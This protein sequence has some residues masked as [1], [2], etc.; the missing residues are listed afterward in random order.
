MTGHRTM[1]QSLT[2]ADLEEVRP[3]GWSFLY[4][5]C[6]LCGY[7]IL[8]PVRDEMAI[9]GGVQ[10]LSGEHKRPYTLSVHTC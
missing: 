2:G 10:H 7:Y 1:I 6:L 9:E 3:L 4:F 8:R 5:F